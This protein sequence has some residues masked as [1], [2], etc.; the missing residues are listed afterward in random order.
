MRLE[1]KVTL[2]S[3]GSSGI[4]RATAMLMA[5][6]GARVVLACRDQ[7]R[8]DEVVREIRAQGGQASLVRCDV[9]ELADCE[10]AV[11][12]TADTWG[13]LDVLF[14]NAGV[15]FPG[16]SVVQTSL[17]EWQKTFD[18]N[19]S[20]AYLM[21][22]FA[23]PLMTASGGGVIINTA[24]DKGLVGR[25][26][27]AAYCASKGAVV[28]LTRAMALD[29]AR[30]GIRVNCICPGSVDTPMLRHEMELLGDRDAM[31]EAFAAKHPLNR[32][33]TPEEVAAVV[34][35]LAS[36]E[37]A[38][39]TGAALSVDGGRLAGELDASLWP[40]PSGGTLPG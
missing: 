16:R 1:G 27:C 32:I 39:I 30:E 36:S 11:A 6:E 2:V 21:S 37:A 5:N 13:R 17:Q 28:Q 3:G 40:R 29:H 15:I 18:T 34:V 4:G 38:F 7:A 10:A 8:G 25:R 22:K 19:V 23:I 31:R 20:G 12:H 26:G 33:C 24:S 14:N 9:C 35:F